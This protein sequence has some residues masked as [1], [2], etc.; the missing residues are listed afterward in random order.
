MKTARRPY[1]LDD[2]DAFDER[3][4]CK[5]GRGVRVPLFLTDGWRAPILHRPGSVRLSDAQID[6]R[7]RAL[8]AR[9]ARLRDAWTG[10]PWEP[11]DDDAFDMASRIAPMLGLAPPHRNVAR[12]PMDADPYADQDPAAIDPREAALA[13][14]DKYKRD[15]WKTRVRR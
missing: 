14:R 4:I 11:D 13:A 1:T 2:D 10:K 9:S 7:E 6:V 3:G 15:A 12:S 5:D 8:A